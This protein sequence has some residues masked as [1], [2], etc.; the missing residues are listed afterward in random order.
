MLAVGTCACVYVCEGGLDSGMDV[1][2]CW[3]RRLL[4]VQGCYGLYTY[5][6][7]VLGASRTCRLQSPD[8]PAMATAG[9]GPA[10]AGILPESGG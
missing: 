7:A 4:A 2:D 10:N 5:I 6:P 3:S 1:D 8:R 9:S